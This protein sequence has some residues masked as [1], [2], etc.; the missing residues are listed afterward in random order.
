MNQT[1]DSPRSFPEWAKASSSHGLMSAALPPGLEIGKRYRVEQLLGRGGM[2]AVYRVHDK[3][4][5]RDVALKLIRTD[6]AEDPETLSRFKREIQLSSKVTH[7]NVLRVYDLGESDGIKFLTMQLVS[8][9]DLSA[10][11][12]K[13]RLPNDRLVKI[14]RQ[15]CE[16][17]NAAHEQGVIH[18]DLKP[19]NVM[20]GE[21]DV[22]YLTDFGLAKSLEQSGLT[23]TGAV[24]GTPFYMSP[25]Q[26][27]GQETD[28]RSDIYSLGI[29]LYQMATGTLPFKGNTPYEVMIQR[30]QR[31]PRP[32]RELNPELSPFLSRIL[33][34][35]LQIDPSLRYQ[36]VAEILSDLE[37]ETFTSSFRYEAGRRR[38]LRPAGA[39]IVAALLLGAAGWWALHRKPAPSAAA[40]PVATT[41]VLIADFENRTGDPVFDGT[42]EPSFGLSLEGAS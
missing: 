10:P 3:D 17:L 5:D 9:D 25:E 33:E 2:G 13:G 18:R 38:W 42:L 22:V 4:L 31:P 37:G 34:R 27:K 39:A 29:I 16:G 11:L 40:A 41:S 35:C 19:Q 7:R 21:G 6:I 1:M 14:F 24:I 32:A 26:V 12:K 23:Q 36:T 28:Q 20:L 8:G 30:V 15:I